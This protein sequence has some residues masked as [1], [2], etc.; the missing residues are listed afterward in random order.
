MFRSI[1]DNLYVQDLRK[2]PAQVLNVEIMFPEANFPLG[3]AQREL[4]ASDGRAEHLVFEGRG[5]G[6]GRR[7]GRR[8]VRAGGVGE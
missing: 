6:E 2:E 8:G 3:V 4:V 7:A 5:W 1:N